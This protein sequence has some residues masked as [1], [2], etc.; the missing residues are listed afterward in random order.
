[1]EDYQLIQQ[2]D[3]DPRDREF[4]SRKI[5]DYNTDQV[6]YNDTRRLTFFILDRDERIVGGITGY[7]HWGWLAVDMLWVDEDLRGQ[8]YGKRLLQAAEAE[9]IARGCRYALLNTMSFQAPEFY[10]RQGYKLYGVLD[11]F[12]GEHQRR[13]YRKDLRINP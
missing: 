11:D 2:D 7:T 8:G 1:M 3:A 12:P 9:A 5:L 6:G 4:I 10:E 13:Y